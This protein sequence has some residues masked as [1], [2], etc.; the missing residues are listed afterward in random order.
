MIK[1]AL[2]HW[3][4]EVCIE[5]VFNGIAKNFNSVIRSYKKGDKFSRLIVKDY[6]VHSINVYD[7]IS[8]HNCDINSLISFYY[9]KRVLYKANKYI[10]EEL[11]YFGEMYFDGELY[12]ATYID[13]AYGKMETAVYYFKNC[14]IE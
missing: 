11:P 5:Q 10:S 4:Y 14:V 6:T 3:I 7:N 12:K 1:V 2:K 8:I 9:E 13:E